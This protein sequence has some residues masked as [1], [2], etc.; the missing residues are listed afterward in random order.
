MVVKGIRPERL[1]WCHSDRIWTILVQCWAQ[2]PDHRPSTQVLLKSI[3]EAVR[4]GSPRVDLE[5]ISR[6][7]HILKSHHHRP[8]LILHL[9][10]AM[11][12]SPITFICLTLCKLYL[13]G[14]RGDW[15]V[16]LFLYYSIVSLSFV[17]SYGRST[18]AIFWFYFF[19]I[20]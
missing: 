14:T 5:E 7:I 10:A 11:M 3:R 15:A 4:H 6:Y 17:L 19:F 18:S 1:D 13:Q 20:L 12:K 8:S 2:N 16:L 9:A